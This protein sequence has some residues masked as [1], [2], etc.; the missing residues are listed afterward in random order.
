[1]MRKGVLRNLR[2]KIKKCV[3]QK[4]TV[5]SEVAV[6]NNRKMCTVYVRVYLVSEGQIILPPAV[7]KIL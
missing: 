5:C 1:M 3:P 2:S 6:L 7:G 4:W